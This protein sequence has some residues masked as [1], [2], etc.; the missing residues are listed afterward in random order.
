MTRPNS[1]KRLQLIS[2]EIDGLR[3]ANGEILD[4]L[5]RYKDLSTPWNLKSIT[6]SLTPWA[7]TAFKICVL[8]D[9]PEAALCRVMSAANVAQMV[10]FARIL[11]ME[12]SEHWGEET[13]D[14]VDQMVSGEWGE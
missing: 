4:A 13:D 12:E 3:G 5:Q 14:A 1:I 11:G 10:I 8:S 7:A 9:N 2:A 6:R